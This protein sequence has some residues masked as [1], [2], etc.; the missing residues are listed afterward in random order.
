MSVHENI[1][2]K[3]IHKSD[4]SVNKK[5]K[6][7]TNKQ[8]QLSRGKKQGNAKMHEKQMHKYLVSQSRS[9]YQNQNI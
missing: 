1:H 7:Q 6:K 5:T 8:K 2:S 3:A 9:K 4:I